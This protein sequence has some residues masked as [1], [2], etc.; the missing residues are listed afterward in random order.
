MCSLNILSIGGNVGIYNDLVEI[1][2][3]YGWSL[4]NCELDDE[5]QWGKGQFSSM[6]I[7]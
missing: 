5:R 2:Q 6:V 1:S 4:I 3:I 7:R